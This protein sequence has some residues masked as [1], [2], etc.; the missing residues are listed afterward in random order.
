MRPDPCFTELLSDPRN[1]VRPLPPSVTLDQARRAADQRLA[2]AP[3]REVQNVRE[4]EIRAGDHSIPARLY[5]SKSALNLPVTLFFHGGGWVWGSLDSHDSICRS[6]ALDSGCA[7]LS[8]GYRLAPEA[9]YPAALEDAVTA[10]E[11]VRAQGRK[12]GL[13]TDR[14]ALCGDSSGGHIALA[15]ALRCDT[16]LRHLGLFYPPIDPTCTSNS[17]QTFA[18]NHLLTREGMLWFWNLYQQNG[19]ASLLLEEDFSHLPPTSIGLAQCDILHD[20]GVFLNQR[21][22]A[23][24]VPTSLRIYEGMIHAFISLPHLTSTARMALADMA[25]DIRIAMQE[26]SV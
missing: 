12:Q 5:L 6:L 21:L 10:L 20:E 24:G 14:I 25:R 26:G 15:V 22:Q 8:V 2:L 19:P 11:W 18:E 1:H 23:A 7:V 17:Q 9:P 13:D 16:P 4:V 3:K